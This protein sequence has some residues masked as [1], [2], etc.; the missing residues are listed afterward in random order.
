[1]LFMMT[2]IDEMVKTGMHFG[3]QA[4]KWNPKMA[5]YIYAERNGIHIID[6]IQTYFYLKKVCKF[7]TENSAKGKTFLFVGTKKQASRLIA[8]T[9][10]NCNSFFVN[11]R[12]LGGMLTNWKTIKTSIDKLNE[13]QKKDL[14]NFPKKEAANLKK[15][16]ERLQKY[17]GG[18]K[19][20]TSIPDVVIIIGQ[21]EELNAV[22]ECQK[23]G[24]R[25]ITILDTNCDPTLADLFIPAN[26]DSVASIQLILT[27]FLE[28][29]KKGEKQYKENK[30]KGQNYGK[31]NRVKNSRE[32]RIK[33]S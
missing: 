9:A 23:L 15:E 7:L 26:D 18:L 6:L 1:M 29:I 21:P 2:T 27:E 4:K 17:L 3:H 19:N 30:R 8:K 11:Q 22:Y 14:D 33:L 12:W 31:E 5:P 20:M 13:L 32:R 24:L 28:A 16:K 25:S 10:L